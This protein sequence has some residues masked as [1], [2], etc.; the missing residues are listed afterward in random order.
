MYINIIAMQLT[1]TC[2]LLHTYSLAR[3]HHCDIAVLLEQ[4]VSLLY[5][6]TQ[7]LVTSILTFGKAVFKLSLVKKQPYRYLQPIIIIV[8]SCQNVHHT[9][10]AQLFMQLYMNTEQYIATCIWC[11]QLANTHNACAIRGAVGIHCIPLHTRWNDHVTNYA[12]TSYENSSIPFLWLICVVDSEPRGIHNTCINI[13]NP[14][15]IWP[16]SFQYIIT[17]KFLRIVIMHF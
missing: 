5:K 3:S 8:T 10:C 7:L 17:I 15:N 4:L 9:M 13:I 14:L 1:N 6:C 12:V 11:L 16:S 2:F